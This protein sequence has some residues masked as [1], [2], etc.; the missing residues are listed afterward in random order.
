LLS[1]FIFFVTCASRKVLIFI[2]IDK[3]FHLFVWNREHYYPLMI[4]FYW[5]I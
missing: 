1:D 3:I 2:E 5:G 4:R